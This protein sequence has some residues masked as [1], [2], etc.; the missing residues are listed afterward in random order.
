MLKTL[1][2]PARASSPVRRPVVDHS[3]FEDAS[4]F[5]LQGLR[6]DSLQLLKTESI[7]RLASTLALKASRRDLRNPNAVADILV[8]HEDWADHYEVVHLIEKSLW[9][10]GRSDLVMT[11]TPDPHQIPDSP[12]QAI[13]DVLS[14]AYARHPDATVWYGVPLFGDET[15]PDGLP[16]PLSAQEVREENARRIRKAQSHALRFGWMYQ[17]AAAGLNV[18]GRAVHLMRQSWAFGTGMADGIR[19]SLKRARRDSRRRERARTC[20][21]MEYV[22]TGRT[23]TEIPE[24]TTSIGK[25]T[26]QAW[27]MALLANNRLGISAEA[28]GISVAGMSLGHML[29]FVPLTVVSADPFLFLELPDEPGKLRHLGHW[30]W[31]DTSNGRQKLHLH[32]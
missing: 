23:W 26:F 5:G 10:N 28:L 6:R 31:Q 9:I 8:Q 29:M 21:Q 12:P 3:A 2:R 15:T 25:A 11:L 19:Q 16:I 13:L 24:H 32:V 14:H 7:G 27:E 22:R 20:A 18:A 17:A 1:S 4:P 30:Y